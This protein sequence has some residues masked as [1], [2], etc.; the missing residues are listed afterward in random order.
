MEGNVL[1]L[2][3]PCNARSV[4]PGIDRASR[5]REFSV[6]SPPASTQLY[7]TGREEK[8]GPLLRGG[9]RYLS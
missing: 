1:R 5:P 8:L 4:L 2:S 7:Y 9:F 3:R 6:E